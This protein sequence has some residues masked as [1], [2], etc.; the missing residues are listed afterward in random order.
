MAFEIAGDQP[1]PEPYAGKPR[2][3]RV[4]VKLSGEAFAG[5]DAGWGLDFDKIDGI[6][7]QLAEVVE[8]GVQVSVVVGAA[9]SSAAR[10]PPRSGWTATVATTWA[11]SAR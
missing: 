8:L 7:S 6:A 9:T 5:D 11:S 10:R 1:A 4:L 2:Y 3:T